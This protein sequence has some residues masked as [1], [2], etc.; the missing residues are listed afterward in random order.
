MLYSLS[1]ILAGNELLEINVWSDRLSPL[2]IFMVTIL[3]A[4]GLSHIIQTIFSKTITRTLFILIFISIISASAWHANM[5]VFSFYENP[6]NYAR[7]HP[8]ELSA[9]YWMRDN[10]SPNSQ[11]ITVNKNRHAEW[12][13]SLTRHEW[14]PVSENDNYFSNPDNVPNESQNHDKQKYVAFFTLRENITPS[15]LQNPD[16]YPRVFSNKAITIYNIPS[17]TK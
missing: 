5:N 4:I 6:D 17:S 9:I 14:L 1:A 15:Y 2:F 16:K 13:P 12:I 10:L 3:S 11:I 8:K 7:L